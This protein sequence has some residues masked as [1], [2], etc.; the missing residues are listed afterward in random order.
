MKYSAFSR[1]FLLYT[2]KGERGRGGKLR[3]RP[4]ERSA[5]PHSEF[6]VFSAFRLPPSALIIYFSIPTSL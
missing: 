2:E 4:E 3:K 6:F 5:P 1:S